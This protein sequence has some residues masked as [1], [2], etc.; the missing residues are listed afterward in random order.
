MT[1][2]MKKRMKKGGNKD[3]WMMYERKKWMDGW[4][5]KN[6]GWIDGWRKKEGRMDRWMME[7]W[8]K[9]KRKRKEWKEWNLPPGRKKDEND[10][11]TNG[12]LDG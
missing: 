12:W 11:W 3:G 10:R 1:E 9:G 5:K 6:E 4:M 8:M 7:G 2:Y